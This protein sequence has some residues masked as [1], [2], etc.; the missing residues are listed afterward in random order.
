MLDVND[1]KQSAIC[2]GCRVLCWGQVCTPGF[3]N[4]IYQAGFN[5]NLSYP[6]LQGL[7]ITPPNLDVHITQKRLW[8][9][10]WRVRLLPSITLNQIMLATLTAASLQQKI[11]N[12]SLSNHLQYCS[13]KSFVLLYS[14]LA[15]SPSWFLE[16]HMGVSL[17]LYLSFLSLGLLSLWLAHKKSFCFRDMVAN[18]IPSFQHN[19]VISQPLQSFTDKSGITK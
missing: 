11:H 14:I 12:T 15:F 10:S 4:K 13:L 18:A 2:R 1:S 8:R 7:V 6:H 19:H 17:S 16:L 5:K 3:I 9:S